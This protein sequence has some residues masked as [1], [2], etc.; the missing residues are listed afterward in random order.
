MTLVGP[1]PEDPRYVDHYTSEQ[2]KVLEVRPGMASPASV[3]YRNEAELLAE[4]GAQWERFYLERVLP[5]KLEL[6]LSYF[7][8]R[9]FRGDV[10]VLAR[11]LASSVPSSRGTTVERESSERES[12]EREGEWRA[13]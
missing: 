13:G 9:S 4:W 10:I 8:R 1:R 2:R 5:D 12:S 6:D 11:A 7:E 3:T